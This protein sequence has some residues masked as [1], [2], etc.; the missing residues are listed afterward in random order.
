MSNS[1]V[2]LAQHQCPVCGKCEDTGELLMDKTLRNRFGM[3][4]VTGFDLCSEC[5]KK[6]AEGFVFIVEISDAHS[7]TF[8]SLTGRSVT[9]RKSVYD[10]I[11]DTPIGAEGMAMCEPAVIDALQ[12]MAEAQH[13]QA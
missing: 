5:K 9:I 1:F 8:E 3:Y 13:A 10:Q 7:R 12:Q 2:T 6:R 4:M 11:F